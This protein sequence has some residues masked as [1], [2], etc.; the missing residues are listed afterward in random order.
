MKT[1]LERTKNRIIYRW[2]A[3]FLLPVMLLSAAACTKKS[4][5]DVRKV[6]VY[7]I[8][9]DETG[10]TI[11]EYEAPSGSTEE[12][13]RI[14]LAY[15]A[16]EPE[17]LTYKAPL[18]MGF[19]ILEMDYHEG[20]LSLNVDEKYQNLSGTTEV[21]V[22]A[23]LVSTL[24]QI[25]NVKR[26]QITV[27]GN[28]LFDS[29]GEAVGWMS[30]DQFIHN[31][32]SE[33]N[34]YEQ[35][36]VKLYFAN[37]SG[38]KLIAVNR[39]KFYSTNISQ[40]RFVVEE[41]LAG[42]DN[43]IEGLYPTINPETKILSIMTKDGICYVNLDSGFMNVVNNVSTEV[44]IYS[45]VDSLVELNYINKVQILINGEVPAVFS[46]KFFERNLDYITVMEQ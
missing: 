41:L 6:Q 29:A 17:R 31:D 26:V 42:P 10:V 40:E 46:N 21:L 30:A 3:V 34:T 36:R 7:Y 5:S 45:I 25:G 28:Q 8:S 18:A 24:T 38:D 16:Q 33:I 32:G 19:Q 9:N 1:D 23:A 20:N 43:K 27:E 4:E 2:I 13:I 11:H 15:L 39:E 37:S 44:A 12:Q 35:V 14:L 22:R